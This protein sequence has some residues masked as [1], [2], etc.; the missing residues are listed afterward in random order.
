MTR[1]G[2]AL[3]AAMSAI[4]GVPYLLIKVA[5]DEV[6]PV[7]VV[8]ARTS[9][10]AVVLVPLAAARGALLP[11]LRRWRPLLLFTALEMAGPWWLLTDA[12]Q[13]LPSS[14]AGL[15]AVGWGLGG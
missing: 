9:V 4:W 14:L 15:L 5:V 7:V 10:A 1:R 2:W 8:F 11:A 6:D 13:H 3:F 12:E